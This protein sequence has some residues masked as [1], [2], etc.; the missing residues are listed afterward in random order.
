MMED[1]DETQTPAGHQ[2][3]QPPNLTILPL[4]DTAVSLQ[5][6]SQVINRSI[7]LILPLSASDWSSS[8]KKGR[9]VPG[10]SW[11][12]LPFCLAA[13]LMFGCSGRFTPVIMYVYV[14][15]SQV[16]VMTCLSWGCCLCH[17]WIP[18]TTPPTILLPPPP[19]PSRLTSWVCQLWTSPFS[20]STS[21]TY[22]RF[23]VCIPSLIR[24]PLK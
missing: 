15:R 14:S 17:S 4:D 11:I 19:W 10:C 18:L 13:L 5:D 24:T 20:H 22:H 3:H 7:S 21:L 12:A 8:M 9:S 2:P 6:H 23:K 16:L 1:S